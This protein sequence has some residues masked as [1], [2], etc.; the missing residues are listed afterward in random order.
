MSPF[1]I[2]GGLPS[3]AVALIVAGATSAAAQVPTIEKLTQIG[4]AEC[5]GPSQLSAIYDVAVTDS[6]D[7]VV[8][9]PCPWMRS[10]RERPASKRN[11]SCSGSV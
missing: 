7:I 4:C 6:G 1:T 9:D 5:G 8:A 2:H 3:I 11:G 10:A